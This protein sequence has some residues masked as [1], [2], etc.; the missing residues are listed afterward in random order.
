MDFLRKETPK[1][2]GIIS[3]WDFGYWFQSRGERPSVSD[4][5]FGPRKEIADWFTDDYTNWDNHTKFLLDERKVDYILM[6]Y[7]LP[8]KY[9]AITAIHSGGKNIQGFLQISPQP[10]NKY[11]QNNVTVI[12]YEAGPLTL[13]L[14][15]RDGNI[16]DAPILLQSSNGQFVNRI[17]INDICTDKGLTTLSNKTPSSGGCLSFSALG[18]NYLPPETK[19]T[20]FSRLMFM[21]GANL[22]VEK[23]FDNSVIKIYKVKK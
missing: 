4:G 16:A 12:E 17:Y 19:N 6:D 11:D 22:P 9:G 5:G 14:P 7:T 13:W 23:V 10:K 21:D 2:S 8:G 1:G 20:I 3:W 15:T 18:A